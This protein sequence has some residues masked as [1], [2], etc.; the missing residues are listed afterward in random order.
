MSAGNRLIL[1]WKAKTGMGHN[2]HAGM[3][4]LELPRWLSPLRREPS[5]SASGFSLAVQGM[6]FD[7]LAELPLN[8]RVLVSLRGC[9][10]GLGNFLFRRLIVRGDLFLAFWQRT[11][12]ARGA[13]RRLGRFQVLRWSWGNQCHGGMTLPDQL[14]NEVSYG[15]FGNGLSVIGQ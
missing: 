8:S 3:I 6:P 1:C 12:R 2:A 9:D 14:Q 4:N 7:H 10:L 13:K 11:I 15:P 5:P